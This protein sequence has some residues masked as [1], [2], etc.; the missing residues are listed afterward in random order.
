MF[1][2]VNND[3]VMMYEVWSLENWVHNERI[4]M[5]DGIW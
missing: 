4:E 2:E 3:L 5:V 1:D